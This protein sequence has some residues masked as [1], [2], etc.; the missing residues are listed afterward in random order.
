MNGVILALLLLFHTPQGKPEVSVKETDKVTHQVLL[1]ALEAPH[2]HCFI[3]RGLNEVNNSHILGSASEISHHGMCV[4]YPCPCCP[5]HPLFLE[6]A[7]N[8][9]F[10]GGSKTAVPCHIS[11]CW[12]M[13]MYLSAP[14][15]VHTTGRIGIL[16]V[17]Q[18]WHSAPK[19][20][21]SSC[22]T[23]PKLKLP[24]L[25]LAHWIVRG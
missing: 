8:T 9:S 16:L 5:H 3:H 21:H 14:F 24:Q 1:R 13:D 23:L 18:R 19:A 17:L 4:I 7:A 11:S 20:A 10:Y 15:S 2:W 12:G 25:Q 22:A 6:Q